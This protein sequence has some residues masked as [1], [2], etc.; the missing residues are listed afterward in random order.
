MNQITINGQ[1]FI[2]PEEVVE[3]IEDLRSRLDIVKEGTDN[4]I[5]LLE[6]Y[7]K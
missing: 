5:K 6:K 3:H 1:L 7:T 2:V 4:I